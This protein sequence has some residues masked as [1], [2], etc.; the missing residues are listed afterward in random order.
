M[1]LSEPI[2]LIRISDG[3]DY[4]LAGLGTAQAL[5]R[6]ETDVSWSII[7]V[8]GAP[9]TPID[10]SAIVPI[11]PNGGQ[12]S[13][14]DSQAGNWDGILRVDVDATLADHGISG[15]ATK[16]ELK[17]TNTLSSISSVGG[18]AITSKKDVGVRVILVPE[19]AGLGLACLAALGALRFLARR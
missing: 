7:E 12:Y 8:N 5:A 13:L 2:S 9:V 18:S 1:S 6:T 19:P 11:L 3:G 4:T 16:V 15:R 14:P 17:I 10:D